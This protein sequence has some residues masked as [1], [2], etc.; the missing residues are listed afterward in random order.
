MN[1][2]VTEM[3]HE[4]LLAHVARLENKGTTGGLKVSEKGGVSFYGVGRWPV[5][6]YA[7]QWA[8]VIAKVKSGELEKFLADNDGKLS[9]KDE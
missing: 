5:T 8:K 1:K 4:E 7:G 6:L 2:P 9:K 3:T